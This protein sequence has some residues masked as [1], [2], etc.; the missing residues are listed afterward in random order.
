MSGIGGQNN[1]PSLAVIADLARSKVN[2]D[3]RGATGTPGEGQIFTNSSVTMINF[4]N[5]AIRDTYRD[6]RI[7]GMKT[8]IK[9]N[10]ILTGITPVNSSMGLGVANPAV[11][12]SIQFVGYFDGLSFNPLITLPADMILPMQMWERLSGTNNPFGP[13]DQAQGS[14]T[15]RNQTDRFGDWEWRSDSIWMVG[16]TQTRDIRLRYIATFADLAASSVDFTSTFVPIADCHEAVA[17]KIAAEYAMRLISPL[18]GGQTVA[19]MANARADRSMR[20]LRQQVTLN[21]QLID[22][23]RPSY[24]SGAAQAAGSPATFLY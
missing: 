17:D 1:Y 23:Q 8:L 20:K 5:S 21:K 4:M 11:Q 22:Y 6:C 13:M 10:Y 19:Q 18:Q 3:K 15:P 9:D 16:S 7:M 2:D 24:G 14:L 12:V